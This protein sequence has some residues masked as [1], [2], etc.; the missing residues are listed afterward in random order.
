MVTGVRNR[1]GVFC[2]IGGKGEINVF[3]MMS[4]LLFGSYF[5]V[6][7][8]GFFLWM[9]SGKG[10]V[11]WYLWVRCL[12]ACFT[13]G[14]ERFIGGLCWGALLFATFTVCFSATCRESLAFLVSPRYQETMGFFTLITTA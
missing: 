3:L 2:F 7:Q 6:G 8:V 14:L 12:Y 5:L 9:V 4:K 1:P 11:F 10:Y 13:V